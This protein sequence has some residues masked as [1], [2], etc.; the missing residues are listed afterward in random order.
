VPHAA[1]RCTAEIGDKP[2]NIVSLVGTQR[3]PV[4]AGPG[5]RHL[6]GK[7]LSENP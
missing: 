6:R 3:D 4:I 7:D 2:G 5:R 1:S